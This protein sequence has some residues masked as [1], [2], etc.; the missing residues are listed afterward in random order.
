MDEPTADAQSAD[1]Q[2]VTALARGLEILRCFSARRPELGTT[3]IALLTGLPQPTVWRLCHTLIKTGY[4]A[5]SPA[6]DKLRIG[7]GV[8]SLGYEAIGAVEIGDLAQREMQIVADDFRSAVSLAIPDRL[9]MVIVKRAQ[10]N[11]RLVVNL[12]AGSR[13]PIG[14]STTGWAYLAVIPAEQRVQLV[15]RLE[16]HYGKREW[17]AK[18]QTASAAI[19]SYHKTG[20]ILSGGAYDPEINAIAIPIQPDDGSQFF[21]LTCGAPAAVVPVKT[22]HLEIAPRLIRV[23]EFIRAALSHTGSAGTVR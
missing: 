22:F 7:V 3:E 10:S 14:A 12:H 8:L 2:F 5:P 6:N 19:K 11:S 21:A 9:D 1:R 17:K 15:N 18:W 20:Y 4:L 16:A 13:L 23:G